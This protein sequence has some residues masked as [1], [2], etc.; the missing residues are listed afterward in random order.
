[1]RYPVLLVFLLVALRVQAAGIVDT[2]VFGD[3]ASEQGHAV[4]D[5]RAEIVTGLL[6]EPARRLLPPERTDWLG[7]TLS[8]DLKVDPA[9]P[10]YFTVRFSGDDAVASRMF[11]VVEGRMIGYLHIGDID[12]LEP[13]TAEP[14][15]PGRFF[16]RTTPLPEALT[17]GRKSIRCEIRSTGPIWGYGNTVERFQKPMTEPTRGLYR[18]YVHTETAF[19]PPAAEKQG[20]APADTV[21]PSPGPEVLQAAKDRVNREI[22]T[23]L[24]DRRP[25]NQMQM[26]FLAEAWHVDWTNA[27]H[28]DAVIRRVVESLDAFGLAY[29]ANPKLIFSDPATPNPDWFGAGPVGATLHWLAKPLAPHLDGRVAGAPDKVTRRQ[30]LAELL[31]RSREQNAVTRRLY[32]NQSMIKDLYGIYYANRG[33]AVVAPAQAW[34]EEK[35]RRYLYEALGL[36]PWLGS[37][38]MDGGSARSVGDNYFQ[39]TGK[40]LT[41]EL[42]YVG[43]YGEVVD[44]VTKIYEA[45]RSA[46]DQAGDPRVRDQ[47]VKIALARAPFRYAALDADGPR[48]MRMETFIGWRDNKYPGLVVY[49]QKPARD[50]SALDAAWATRDPRLLAY[51]RQMIGDNQFFASLAATMAENG[52]LRITHGLLE[53]PAAYRG[54]TALPAPTATQ[55]L[56]MSPGAPDFVFTDEED[57][58]VALKHGD[59][60]LYASLYWRARNAVNFLAAVHLV[61]PEFER[62]AIVREEIRFTPSGSVYR[63]PN[64]V[65]LGFGNGGANLKYEPGSLPPSAHAGEELPIAAIPP[66]IPY[67]VGQENVFAGKG[68]FYVLR[69]GDYL[70]AMNLTANRPFTFDVPAEFAAAH[71]L[72]RPAA[73]PAGAGSRIV[74]PRSTVILRRAN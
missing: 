30:L 19:T 5:T 74:S 66:G 36:Q 61:T 46:P 57:G 72:V 47:L 6:G 18:A 40:G 27:Y 71:D 45:T 26:M 7:G 68:D 56:P 62:Q 54:I 70:I 23:R 11:L 51:A 37:D 31:A 67:K 29:R 16:Y 12:L 65:V 64:A 25:L 3:A 44:W 13:G 50:A 14:Q 1:M 49:G 41:K 60:V 42:G 39:L 8:F 24:N 38:L 35:A 59:E 55:R 17:Q 53:A 32:T 15:S 33:L 10:N 20:V 48:A 73:V 58:V 9:A 2:V 28:Q 22:D 4:K 43:S 52:S 34:P 21:R 63:R 69:Y